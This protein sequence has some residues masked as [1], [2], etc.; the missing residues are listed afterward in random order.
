MAVDAAVK[1][2]L[3]AG[4]RENALK[5]RRVRL[6]IRFALGTDMPADQHQ[7]AHEP[8]DASSSSAPD[9]ETETDRIL[10]LVKNQNDY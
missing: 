5:T 4:W 9:L 2:S 6:A 3:Q 10:A 7:G 8:G 1:A